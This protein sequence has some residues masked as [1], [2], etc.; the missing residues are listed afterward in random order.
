MSDTNIRTKVGKIVS[1]T[2]FRHSCTKINEKPDEKISHNDGDVVVS[3]M[4][5][6]K[7]L[8]KT[9]LHNM[10]NRNL[11]VRNSPSKGQSCLCICV[12]SSD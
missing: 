12:Y 8:A 1:F 3:I 6:N 2:L 7:Y 9:R 5:G 11:N 10:S 4:C